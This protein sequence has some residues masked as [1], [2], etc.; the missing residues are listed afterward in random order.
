MGSSTSRATRRRRPA[1]RTGWRPRCAFQAIDSL[2]SEQPKTNTSVFGEAERQ[3]HESELDEP[4]TVDAALEPIQ[5]G[6]ARS[7]PAL[8][9]VITL[10]HAAATYVSSLLG[11]GIFA[12]PG[13]AARVP[14]PPPVPPWPFVSPPTH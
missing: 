8:R 6:R 7:P 3:G 9:R 14:G 2:P 13:L 10:R 12:I 11:S 5:E 4:A 1:T